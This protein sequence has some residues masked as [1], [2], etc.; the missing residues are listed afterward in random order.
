MKHLKMI[1]WAVVILALGAGGFWF[2]R[3]QEAAA[4]SDGELKATG[5]IEARSA[6]LAPEVG[7]RVLEVLVEEGERVTA[8]QPLVRLDDALLS[9]QM[10][11]AQAALEAAQANLEL[12]EA[13]V[14]QEQIVA[15]EAQLAAAEASLEAARASLSALTQ[16]ARPEEVTALRRALAQARARYY[17]VRVLFTADQIEQ[18]REALVTA[19]GNLSALQDRRDELADDDRNPAYVVAAL[20][21]TL[22]GTQAALEAARQVYDVVRD[23]G[24]PYHLQVEA[25]RRSWEMAQINL[26]QVQAV[27]EGLRDDANATPDARAALRSTL[28]EARDLEAAAQAAYEALTSGMSGLQLEAAWKQ[29]QRLQAELQATAVSRRAG[30]AAPAGSLIAVETAL[31]Q[32]DVAVAQRDAAAANL[33]ALRRGA[34]PEEIEVARAQVRAAQAQVEAL[35][36]QMDKL[37]ITAPWDG[38]VLTRS[39]EPGETVLPGTTLLEVGRLDVL[40]L[41]VYLPEDRF[42]RVDVGQGAEVRV[43]AYPDR[44]FRGTVLRIADEAEFTPTNIQTEDNRVRLVYAVVIELEN[45][46]LA[47]KPGMIADVEF[48]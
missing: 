39:V 20:D 18:V 46:D 12:L 16:S 36:V 28:E 9:A 17:E 38:I 19:E 48:N 33:A 43:D 6:V 26:A 7:G 13:G 11:Q 32:V 23:A 22:V 45:D 14:P 41:T 5:V 3:S 21:T 27:Y 10:A 4:A 30:A 37:T 34:L 24:Q 35:E 8:G 15:A 29:V 25:A 42:G 44:V 40:E 2:W 47:L 1:I 31:A